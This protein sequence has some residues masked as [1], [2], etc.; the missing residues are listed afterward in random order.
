MLRSCDDYSIWGDTLEGGFKKP[1][2]ETQKK[3]CVNRASLGEAFET[4]TI[5]FSSLD[6]FLGVQMIE[7][8]IRATTAKKS[9]PIAEGDSTGK[10][11]VPT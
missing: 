6:Y 11:V 10:V 3:P 1:A 8:I 7:R 4:P 9:R 2:Q 5:S